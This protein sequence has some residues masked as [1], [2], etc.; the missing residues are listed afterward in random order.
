MYCHI[1]G[2]FFK[3]NLPPSITCQGTCLEEAGA[4]S[5]QIMGKVR[6]PA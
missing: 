5:E 4:K 2:G 6:Q 3:H 1:M